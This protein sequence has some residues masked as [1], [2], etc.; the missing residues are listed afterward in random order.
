MLTMDEE[1][2]KLI[3][4]ASLEAGRILDTALGKIQDA[5]SPE[6]LVRIRRAIG[7]IMGT[8]ADEILNPIYRQYPSIKP[9]EY[10]LGDS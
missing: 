4:E 2:G 7:E 10:Y 9:E 1:S 8:L 5:A 6:E 3:T